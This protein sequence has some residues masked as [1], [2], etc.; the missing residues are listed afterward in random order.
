[1]SYR[2]HNCQR[3]EGMRLAGN[4]YVCLFAN[5]ASIA[6]MF[7][8]KTQDTLG[9]NLRPRTYYQQFSFV[10]DFMNISF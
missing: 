6:D 10:Q 9:Q 4:N 5:S 7:R 8:Q 3:D 2:P 1:M